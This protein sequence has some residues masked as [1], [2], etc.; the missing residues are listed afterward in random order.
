[1][2]FSVHVDRQVTGKVPG[3]YPE[4]TWLRFRLEYEL[5]RCSLNWRMGMRAWI[6]D[7]NSDQSDYLDVH[8]LR[9]DGVTSSRD[10]AARKLR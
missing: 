1:M 6:Q 4:T 8:V 10:A 5:T 2:A 9:A 7:A 3:Q